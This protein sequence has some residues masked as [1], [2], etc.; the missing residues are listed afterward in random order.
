M[1]RVKNP[2][3]V[4]FR[5]IQA[6]A[7]RKTVLGWR[8]HGQFGACVLFVFIVREATDRALDNFCRRHTT[9]NLNFLTESRMLRTRPPSGCTQDQEDTPSESVTNPP[10]HPRPWEIAKDSHWPRLSYVY[11]ASRLYW[12]WFYDLTITP[13]LVGFEPSCWKPAFKNQGGSFDC[14]IYEWITSFKLN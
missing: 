9:S 4:A 7:H 6:T 1:S 5:F 3:T 11:G 2:F 14:F 8:A 13:L 12:F 10:N